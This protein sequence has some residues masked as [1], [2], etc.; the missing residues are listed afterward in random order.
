MK[1]YLIIFIVSIG[2]ALTGNIRP[3]NGSF[4]TYVYVP[5]EWTQEPDAISYNLEISGFNNLDGVLAIAV[6]NNAN[7]FES[8]SQAYLDSIVVIPDNEITKISENSLIREKIKKRT[9]RNL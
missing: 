4:L 3:S 9:V 8:E 2:I 5:F 7:S 6:F 1:K